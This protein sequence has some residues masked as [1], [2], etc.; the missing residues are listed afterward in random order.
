MVVPSFIFPLTARY[1]HGFMYLL[2]FMF[3]DIEKSQ[4]SLDPEETYSC[5]DNKLQNRGMLYFSMLLY[6]IFT[7]L[8]NSFEKQN[9]RKNVDF[10]TIEIW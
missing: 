3:R 2:F 10:N 6:V 1:V 5:A 9:V 4:E 7:N 8:A